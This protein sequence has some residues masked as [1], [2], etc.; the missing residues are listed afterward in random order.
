MREMNAAQSAARKAGK[1]LL[2]RFGRKLEVR[3]KGRIDLVTDADVRAERIIYSALEKEFPGHGFILEEGDRQRADDGKV[4]VVDPI[5]GTTNFSHAY[6]F[7]CVSIGLYENGKGLLGVVYDPLRGEMFSAEHGKGAG[8]N[9]KRI[10]VS[11]R[12]RLVD[13]LVGADFPYELGAD[14]KKT[15]RQY[16]SIVQKSQGAR[17]VGAAA[18]EL[19]NVACGRIDAFFH[20]SLQPYDTAAASV[21]VREAGGK[22]TDFGGKAHDIFNKHIV[23]SNSKVHREL[24]RALGNK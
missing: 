9:G 10:K 15:A 24:L 6:P 21:I 2:T 16:S 3:H 13:C 23:A 14:M 12:G 11:Q 20:H 17:T 7:F 1:F 4:W 8:L 22:T 18:L 19:C 5:D